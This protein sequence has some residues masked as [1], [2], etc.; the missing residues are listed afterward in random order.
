MSTTEPGVRA[1]VT[2]R[3]ARSLEVAGI[4]VSAVPDDLDLLQA[5]IVDSFGFLELIGEVEDHFDLAVDFEEIDAVELTAFGSFCRFIARAAT[6]PDRSGRASAT[7]GLETS[8]APD[9]AP[10]LVDVV[11]GRPSFGR[12]RRSLGV[13]AVGFY[14]FSSRAWAKIFSGATSGAFA[15]FGSNS[16][17]QPP[18][19]LSGESRIAVGNGVYVGAGSWLQ[20]LPG[21]DD[22]VAISIGDRTGIAGLCVV[23]AVSSIR[24]GADV[25]IARGVY[26]AD[27]SHAYEDTDQPIQAQG[28]TGIAPVEIGDG[29]WL[30]ENSVVL[31]GVRIG[32]GAV[33]SANSVVT[34]SVLDHTVVA[35]APARIVR[36]ITGSSGRSGEPGS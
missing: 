29:A 25:S 7:S 12:I 30:G 19:R 34:R 10:A 16:V 36:R 17:I 1:F 2:E 28:L 35:G 21:D 26:I 8:L 13:G 32:R 22:G 18:V 20:V 31:P 5:S 24:I 11:D 33:V 14:R 23:S 4:D 3:L 9:Q 6:D 27:H 15:S